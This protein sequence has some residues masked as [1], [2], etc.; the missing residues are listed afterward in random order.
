MHIEFLHF[1]TKYFQRDFVA[2]GHARRDREERGNRYT[3]AESFETRDGTNLDEQELRKT[4]ELF[5]GPANVTSV[6]NLTVE[7]K[8]ERIVFFS[9]LRS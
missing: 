2:R 5:C 3:D 8:P 7:G 4:W 1:S 9:Q 6:E